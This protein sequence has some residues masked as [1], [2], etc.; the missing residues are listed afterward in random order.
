MAHPKM[1]FGVSHDIALFMFRK[2]QLVPA[3]EIPETISKLLTW[4]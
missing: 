4:A 1:D 3:L 2:A